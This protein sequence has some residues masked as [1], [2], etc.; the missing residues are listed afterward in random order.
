MRRLLPCL[1]AV[2][3]GAFVVNGSATEEPQ[4]IHVKQAMERAAAYFHDRIGNQGFYVWAY[5]EDLTRRRAEGGEVRRNVAWNQPPGSPSVG[6]AYIRMFEA[7][8]D[9][10]WLTAAR[11]TAYALISV[12]LQSGGWYYSAE[13]DP[14]GRRRW[15]YISTKDVPCD[16]IDGNKAKNRTVLDDDTTQSIVRFLIWYDLA[17]GKTDRRVRQAIDH[18][19]EEV[20]ARQFPNGS[21]PVFSDWAKDSG[22]VD[23]DLTA[24]VP[25][26]LDLSSWLK[27]DDPPYFVT[28]DNIVLQTVRALIYADQAYT[29]RK[30]I[31]SAV[32]AGEFLLAAQLPTPLPG[33][34]QTYNKNMHPTWGRVFE[35]P[36]VSSRETAGAIQT[37]LLLHA[38]IG[39]AKYLAAAKNALEWL[40]SVQ[41]SNGKWARFYDLRTGKPLYVDSNNRVTTSDTD[42]L[43]HYALKG[44]FGIPETIAMAEVN[45]VATGLIAPLEWWSHTKHLSSP[46]LDEKIDRLLASQDSSGRWVENGEI[47]SDTFVDAIFTMAH[48]LD[49]KQAK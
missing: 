7:T 17:T 13:T 39:D 49:I 48:Y 41:L 26:N 10:T 11:T 38:R 42:L 32:E 12:Q 29:C 22:T 19:L 25:D 6:A 27:P 15:C 2:I 4:L 28:N 43:D 20:M 1:I 30:C 16:S 47:K 44:S 46:L 45:N 37:L 14:E 36:A 23:P 3:L 21:F 8:G 31:E 5:S 40:K 34:A 9:V 24:R 18:A 35:P 33:W